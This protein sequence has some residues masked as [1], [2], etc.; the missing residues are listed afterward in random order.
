[1]TPSSQRESA[2]IYQF[3]I[4]TRPA[5]GDQRDV[6][7]RAA[8]AV[9]RAMQLPSMAVAGTMSRRFWRTSAAPVADARDAGMATG[10][11]VGAK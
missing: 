7:N 6:G 3:P 2:T 8:A 10:P 11:S 5:V 1:M 9:C 4:R